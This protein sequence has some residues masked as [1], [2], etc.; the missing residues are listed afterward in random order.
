MTPVRRIVLDI[1][2]PARPG[3][4]T[5]SVSVD[6][7]SVDYGL[8]CDRPDLVVNLAFNAVDRYLA[9]QAQPPVTNEDTPF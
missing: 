7:V 2:V 8:D 9:L 4:L 3:V 5:W 6:G 1:S